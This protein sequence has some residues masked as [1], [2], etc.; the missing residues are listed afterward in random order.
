MH[1]LLPSALLTA[2]ILFSVPL[3]ADI[4]EAA[5]AQ[6]AIQQF[7]V[8]FPGKKV[9]T[10]VGFSGKGYQDF[11]GVK[12]EVVEIMEHYPPSEWIVNIGGTPDGIGGLYPLLKN[13]GYRT[14][15]IVSQQVVV[16]REN[17]DRP[18]VEEFPYVDKVVIVADKGWGGFNKTS[19]QL[20][21]T[22]RAMVGV[23]DSMMA[24]GGGSVGR[25]E[26]IAAMMQTHKT[27]PFQFFPYEMNHSVKLGKHRK[28]HRGELSDAYQ[29]LK[30][31]RQGGF[32]LLK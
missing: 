11:E 20:S 25:D 16:E 12:A 19:L 3:K 28:H 9:L 6:E 26:M 18:L 31:R 27:I 2:L 32:S 22:S 24:F 1:R 8:W 14:T 17:P 23:I 7:K 29:A 4:I 13:L 21:P 15:G 5:T 30:D 10:F